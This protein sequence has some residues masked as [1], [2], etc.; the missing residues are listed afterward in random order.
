MIIG[1]SVIAGQYAVAQTAFSRI[2][3]AFPVLVLSPILMNKFIVPS[4]F[5]QR[6]PILKFPAQLTI[7]GG[8]LMTALPCALAIFPPIGTIQVSKLER[9]FHDLLDKSGKPLT[10]VLYNKGL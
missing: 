2:L 1:Q 8:L 10:S 9:K 5:F 4:A 3:T 7:I 6:Y